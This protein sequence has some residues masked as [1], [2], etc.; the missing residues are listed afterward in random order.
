MYG[1]LSLITCCLNMLFENT[2]WTTTR[3]FKQHV[4]QHVFLFLE[5]IPFYS[6]FIPWIVS[7]GKKDKFNVLSRRFTKP[8]VLSLSRRFT[9]PKIKKGFTK[10]PPE[11]P[12]VLFKELVQTTCFFVSVGKTE[13]HC[14]KSSVS[15]KRLINPCKRLMYHAISRHIKYQ[16]SHVNI[17]HRAKYN[18]KNGVRKKTR[19]YLQELKAHVLTTCFFKT[20]IYSLIYSLY[21]QHV[22]SFACQ[23]WN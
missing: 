16:I 13:S 11:F 15:G 7:V 20:L 19:P 1:I 6:W 18:T 9:K 3:V 8:K 21:K 12:H 2:C 4:K 23:Y 14:F 5:F 22:L 17:I 10:F